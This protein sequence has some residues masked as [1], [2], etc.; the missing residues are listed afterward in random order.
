MTY[1]NHSPISG[2]DLYLSRCE[3]QSS[4]VA[5]S[6]VWKIDTQMDVAITMW[7]KCMNTM[8]TIHHTQLYIK[9]VLHRSICKGFPIQDLVFQVHY[10]SIAGT[11]LTNHWPRLIKVLMI[12][13]EPSIAVKLYI[14]CSS[15]VELLMYKH[16]SYIGDQ[17]WCLDH[18][19]PYLNQYFT[20]WLLDHF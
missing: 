2:S 17:F 7:Y 18:I 8:Y 1:D 3:M 6:E 12:I 5:P 20:T 9:C 11:G 15:R 13:I 16:Y 14:L 10:P 4:D 19:A